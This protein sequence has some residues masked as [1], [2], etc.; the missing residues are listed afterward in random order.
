MTPPAPHTVNP[1]LEAAEQ[2]R[3]R[4]RNDANFTVEKMLSKLESAITDAFEAKR[5]D[6][7]SR[8]LEQQAKLS[9]V[10]IELDRIDAAV[11]AAIAA[12][13]GNTP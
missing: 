11:D 5:F 13:V 8:L 12:P 6:V 9:S 3:H 2:V 1:A 10:L 4:V 7:F